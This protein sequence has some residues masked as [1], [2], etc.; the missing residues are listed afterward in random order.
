MGADLLDQ[1]VSNIT[2]HHH[3]QHQST[4]GVRPP[5]SLGYHG[6]F[7]HSPQTGDHGE[8]HEHHVDHREVFHDHGKIVADDR[9]PRVRHAGQNSGID[10]GEVVALFVFDGDVVEK[11][12]LLLVE[13]DLVGV[14]FEFEQQQL[15]GAGRTLIIGEAFQQ[16]KHVDQRLVG[17]RELDLVLDLVGNVAD[18][19]QMLQKVVRG[20]MKQPQQHPLNRIAPQRHSPVFKERHRFGL[21][22]DDAVLEQKCADR[23]HFECHR[24]VHLKVA[25][26]FENHRDVVVFILHTGDLIF[27]QRG[28]ERMLV[29][30]ALFDQITL[31]LFGRRA[32]HLNDPELPFRT[33]LDTPVDQII[34][35]EHDKSIPEK[36]CSHFPDAE[37]H[38]NE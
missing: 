37:T 3:H 25:R 2:D 21:K 28:N 7:R 34:T 19:P 18:D 8:R 5:D 10:S 6:E 14:V 20:V 27:I 15:I 12:Q 22:H 23:R 29:N 35:S 30:A 13:T 33:A 1:Q 17:H 38:R 24:A 36:N 4:V 32:V 26:A 31:L 16:R 11:I 9:N